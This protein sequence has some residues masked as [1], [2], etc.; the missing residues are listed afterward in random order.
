[1]PIHVCQDR[2][3]SNPCIHI[4]EKSIEDAMLGVWFSPEPDKI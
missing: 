2:Q 3:Y 4:A 1:M